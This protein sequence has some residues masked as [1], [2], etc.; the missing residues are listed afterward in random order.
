MIDID[1]NEI[2][3]KS[4]SKRLY[5]LYKMKLLTYDNVESTLHGISGYCSS[6]T[7]HILIELSERLYHKVA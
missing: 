6:V 7:A 5:I 1:V 3:M 4:Y 2:K